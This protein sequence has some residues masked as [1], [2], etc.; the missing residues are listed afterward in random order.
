MAMA[1]NVFLVFFYGASPS[2]FRR[3]LWLYCLVCFGG[4]FIPA[5]VLLLARPGGQHMYGNAT[6]H[7][8]PTTSTSTTNTS[9]ALV[10]D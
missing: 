4:P 5:I 6:V 1:I 2:S 9:T 7:S 10:L 3:Y 8:A